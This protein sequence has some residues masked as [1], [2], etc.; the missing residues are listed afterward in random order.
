MPKPD[1]LIENEKKKRRFIKYC[2]HCRYFGDIVKQTK[3][4]RKEVVDVHECA[5]HHG[6]FNTKYSVGCSDWE[7][8]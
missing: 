3:H 2:E 7:G 5:I 1:W 8:K 4:N 6:C